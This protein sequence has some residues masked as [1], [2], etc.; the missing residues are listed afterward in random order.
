M[1]MLSSPSLEPDTTP[2]NQIPVK[3]VRFFGLTKFAEV[4][5][6]ARAKMTA[7]RRSYEPEEIAEAL[8]AL[9]EGKTVKDVA[10][11]HGISLSCLKKYRAVVRSGGTILPLGTTSISPTFVELCHHF[12][13]NIRRQSLCCF[14]IGL[15]ISIH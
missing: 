13:Q 10:K 2:R 4:F 5:S 11:E 8:D 9:K 15:N 1:A 7:R 14:L 3:S 6:R 12:C